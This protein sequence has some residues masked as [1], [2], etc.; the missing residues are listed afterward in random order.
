MYGILTYIYLQYTFTI[1]KSTI[2]VG[3]Y[4]VHPMDGIWVTLGYI[5][6]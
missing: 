2:H 6:H 3:K 5:N 4:A 1:N